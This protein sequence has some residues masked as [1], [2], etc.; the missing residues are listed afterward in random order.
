[1]NLWNILYA[2]VFLKMTNLQQL[3]SNFIDFEKNV[4][5]RS[6]VYLRYY[7]GT[8]KFIDY[9][10][11]Y[12]WNIDTEEIELVDILNYFNYYKTHKI[13]AWPSSWKYPSRNWLYN[14]I[15]SI[16]MFF[17]YCSIIGVKL[18]FNWEQIPIFKMEEIR[19][20]PMTKEDF[21]ILRTAPL[22]Y[23][24]LDRQDIIFRDQ[25]I[26]EIPRE[27]W[28]RR[29]ELTRLKFEHF[30]ASNRQF[31][32][33]VKWGR[34]ENVF[35]NE[36][37]RR[38]ILKYEEIVTNKYKFINPE[39]LFFYMGQKEIGKRMT[40]HTIWIVVL[41]Y[42]KKLKSDWKIPNDKKLCLHMERHSFAM[43][44]VYS[45]LSQQ[46]TTALMRHKDPKITLHYYHMNDTWLLNQYDLIQ[47]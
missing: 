45:G 32:I 22:L 35:F 5:N 16:R 28:L 46:A 7:Y 39:Y 19:R 24:D 10:K 29:A 21:E 3:L 1:M 9:I 2:Y 34:F 38:K 42:I 30:H 20:E 8:K 18:K 40:P 36:K 43:K 27:T 12:R 41:E 14:N 44:C 31:Q 26:F 4:K 13:K 11:K 25:L 37:L 6:F 23:N 17:R 47:Y 15:V 33:E